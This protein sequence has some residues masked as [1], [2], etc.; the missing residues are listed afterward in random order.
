MEALAKDI[1]ERV[2]NKKLTISGGEPLL[3]V[4]A[5]VELMDALS[6][7]SISLY[8]GEEMAQVSERVLRYLDFIK[9]GRYVKALRRTT[10]PYIGSSNQEFIILKKG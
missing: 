4:E 3:Q 6:D 7:F 2:R 1:R 5:L 8:T 10:L 9:V